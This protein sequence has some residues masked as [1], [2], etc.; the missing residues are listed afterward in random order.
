M[1]LSTGG[2]GCVPGAQPGVEHQWGI[3]ELTGGT[4]LR[5]HR[6]SVSGTGVMDTSGT[7]EL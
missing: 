5:T 2:A 7:G 4:P 6:N 1:L 3:G